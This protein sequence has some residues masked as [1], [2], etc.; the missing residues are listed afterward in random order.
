MAAA[1]VLGHVLRYIAE[2][3]KVC[4]LGL[5]VLEVLIFSNSVITCNT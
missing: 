5:T 1:E 2:N 3:E 4:I